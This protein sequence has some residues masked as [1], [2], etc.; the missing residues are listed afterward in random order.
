[1]ALTWT[2]YQASRFVCGRADESR[3]DQ[4]GFARGWSLGHQNYGHVAET[5]FTAVSF[6]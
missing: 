1:M 3:A 4:R 2:V 6:M 5:I